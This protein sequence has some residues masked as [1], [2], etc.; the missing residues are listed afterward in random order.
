MSLPDLV[1]RKPVT[2]TMFYVAVVLLGIFSLGRLAIDLIPEVSF[3]SLSISSSYSG[4]A[5][6]EIERLITIPLEQ[7]VSSVS[8]VTNM[9]SVSQEGSS[10]ITLNFAWGTNL[11]SAANE[12][13]AAVER[14]RS[15]LPSEA[16]APQT[17]SYDLSASP[18][19]TIAISGNVDSATL[20]RM[21]EEEFTY[22]LERLDGVAAVTVQGGRSREILVRVDPIRLQAHGITIDQVVQAIRAENFNV[23]AG[24]I[25]VG[26]SQFTLRSIG[27]VQTV[28]ELKS[29]LIARRNDVRT[30]LRDIAQV[31]QSGEDGGMIVRV[32]GL[33]GITISVQKQSG[34]NTVQTA[35]A[36]RKTL[37]D[38]RQRFPGINIRVINDSSIYIR[39]AINNVVLS[40]LIGALLAALVLLLFLQ[41]VR[42]TVIISVAIPVSFIG[43][44]IL[45]ERAGMTLNLMSLGGLALGVGMLVDNSIVVLENTFRHLTHGKS[46]KEA[47][48]IGTQEMMPAVIASTLTTLAVFL[49]MMFVSGMTGIL[50]RQLSMMVAFSILCSLAVALTLLPV[51]SAHMLRRDI[52]VDKHGLFS[53]LGNRIKNGFSQVE[54]EYAGLIRKAVRRPKLV[55]GASAAIFILSLLLVPFLGRELITMSDEGELSVSFS[56]PSGTKLETTDAM[57]QE[58]ESIIKK[59]VP[60]LQAMDVRVGSGSGRGTNS[61]SANLVLVARNKRQRSTDDIRNALRDRLA[62]IPGLTS[63]VSVRSNMAER[64]ASGSFGGGGSDR[65][66]INVQGYQLDTIRQTANE[67]A[68]VIE[69][70]PGVT[71]ASVARGSEQPEFILRIDKDRAA[72]VGLS[73]TQIANAVQA[74]VQGRSASQIT[75]NGDEYPIRVAVGSATES[76]QPADI[77]ALPIPVGGGQ[78]VLL[79]SVG[80]LIT[81]DSPSAIDR[82]NQQ[83]TARITASP[84]GRDLGSVIA[85]IRTAIYEHGLPDGVMVYFGGEYEEQQ[86]AFREMVTVILLAIMLVYAVMAAQFESLFD[87]LLIMFSVPFAL[88][89]VI[90]TLFLTGT[91][92]TTQ[93]FMGLIMLGGIV[94]NNAI[95][96]I[97]YTSL[98]REQGYGLAEAVELSARTRL[99]PILMTTG[100]TILGLLPMALALGEGAEIQAPLART[101]IGG[102]SVSTAVTLVLIPTLY[103]WSHRWLEGRREGR[104]AKKST[105]GTVAVSVALM[106]VLLGGAMIHE[107]ARAE[108]IPYLTW[109]TALK[110]ALQTNSQMQSARAK[111]ADA[112][113]KL[114]EAEAAYRA[115]FTVDGGWEMRKPVNDPES[116]YSRQA[117]VGVQLRQTLGTGSLLGKPN[118]AIGA[119]EAA[120][121][122]ARRELANVSSSVTINLTSA[123]IDVLNA[124]MQLE[125]SQRSQQR[126]VEVVKEAEY[127]FG[128]KMMTAI[129]VQQAKAQLTSANISLEK[130][131][132]TQRLALSR[133]NMQMGVDPLTKWQIAPV[134]EYANMPKPTTAATTDAPPAEALKQALE[135]YEIKQ[136]RSQ[137]QRAEVSA[138]NRLA[139]TAPVFNV[140][141]GV[142][143]AEG[144]VSLQWDNRTYDTTLALEDDLYSKTSGPLFSSGTQV[145]NPYGSLG[146]SVT[147]PLYDGG[148]EREKAAQQASQLEQL[149]NQ[150]KQQER[151]ITLEVYEAYFALQEAGMRAEAAAAAKQTAADKLQLA[152]QR[153]ELGAVTA[154]EVFD[155]ELASIQAEQAKREADLAV[156]LADMRYRKAAGY[157]ITF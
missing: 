76:L 79:K 140:T 114:R 113:S 52:D 83:R 115:R 23:P 33:P 154:L 45:I 28:D 109:E 18:I 56:L 93:A 61:G 88:V 2:T 102:L 145:K 138:A 7:A 54:A 134:K 157:E 130:A 107:T 87:P 13:R 64:M 126:A 67:L 37:D 143:S 121:D 51:M 3:P 122:A 36:V 120:V 12:V 19:M 152:R 34:A 17:G 136:I 118:E 92:L 20:R 85:D 144:R 124:F 137:L 156:L 16:S 38:L 31:E 119:A 11:D 10:R 29:V 153:A 142:T 133:L 68:Q 116:E 39:K 25:V 108:E 77:E 74:A 14:V 99:R 103:Q 149:R 141:A 69:Q 22:Y 44:F 127:R 24:R 94:V 72:D 40:G 65:I 139:G 82:L 105:A 26:Q 100:T 30:Y 59:E 117:S 47:A 106:C 75:I 9:S 15:R 1:V 148:V 112:E 129:D 89:G 62:Q 131:Q 98:L 84:E 21:A 95:I 57:A 155:A 146:F 46:P 91:P 132:N 66:T 53:K 104:R 63:R 35:A 151:Q 50:F 5:P 8:G 42:L 147:W 86:R 27:E 55:A 4:V 128:Q 49:P 60:E 6:E 71:D 81:Q 111:L 110:Q 70:V 73:A 97:S 78:F 101:V 123:Y 58:I 150:V 41:S 80:Q 96:L 32:D 135:R 48:V 125:I 90:L 43:A